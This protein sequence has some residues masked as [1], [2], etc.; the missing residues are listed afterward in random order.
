MRKLEFVIGGSTYQVEIISLNMNRARVL[1]NGVEY[2]VEISGGELG[3]SSTA[4]ANVVMASPVTVPRPAPPAP[5][6]APP[7]PR[8]EGPPGG[9][10]IKAPMPGL[11]LEVKVGVGNRVA[12]G[13]VVCRMEA[14]KMENNIISSMEGQVQAV[15]VSEGVE[16]QTG[17]VL[18]VIG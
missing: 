4:A 13:D 11:I 14:M 1:V 18:V 17:Q 2:D 5:R 7:A 10:E 12:R 8:R 6:P 15:N 3:S 9:G 16:V